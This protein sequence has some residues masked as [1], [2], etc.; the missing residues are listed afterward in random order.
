ME[1]LQNEK[2]SKKVRYL[3]DFVDIKVSS[4]LIY[5]I[6]GSVATVWFV[7]YLILVPFFGVGYKVIGSIIEKKEYETRYWVYLQ[8]ENAESKNYKVEGDIKRLSSGNYELKTAYWP[9]GGHTDF[10]LCDITVLTDSH[11]R[12]VSSSVACITSE[13]RDYS[14]SIGERV[15]HK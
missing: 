4:R 15:I 2:Q 14:V 11:Y 5:L 13:N 9:N 3:I 10:D 6:L 8:P 12:E 7:I 1:T